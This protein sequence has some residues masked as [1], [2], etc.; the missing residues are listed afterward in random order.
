MFV[1]P[2]MRVAEL[3]LVTSTLHG[4]PDGTRTAS[5]RA[6]QP[7][8]QANSPP[9]NIRVFGIGGGGGN[10]VNRMVEALDVDD[11]GEEASLLHG[12]CQPP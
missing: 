5:A 3:L 9:V 10:A 2:W 7:G 11:G 1:A 8:C 4:P 6:P 12:G